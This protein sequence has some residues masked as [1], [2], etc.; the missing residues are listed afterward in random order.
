MSRVRD[1]TGGSHRATFGETRPLKRARLGG[2]VYD[3]LFLFPLLCRD[4]VRSVGESGAALWS[5]PLPTL[6]PGV[7]GG[8]WQR[9]CLGGLVC[10]SGGLRCVHFTL[11]EL[12][13]KP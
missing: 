6:C 9:S 11:W 2:F 1:A 10:D 7:G 4:G 8:R 5:L 13:M 3:A 12:A